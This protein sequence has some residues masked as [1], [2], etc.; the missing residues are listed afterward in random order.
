MGL[1]NTEVWELVHTERRK[2]VEDLASVSGSQ[3]ETP[4]LCPGWSVHDVLAHLVDTANTGRL[5]FVWSMMR[6]RGDFDRANAEG[7]TRYKSDDPGQTVAALRGMLELTKTPP[8]NRATR[9]V[10][11]FVHGEDI[12]RPLR[13]E[14]DYPAEG[15][16]EALTYQLRTAV[17][18]GGGKERAQ[19]LRLIDADGGNS[20]GEGAEVSGSL[21]DLL[22]VISGRPVDQAR[23]TGPGADRL[24][25]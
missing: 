12:R 11:A 8:A 16:V 18:F 1:S 13:I 14:G 4:S 17:S 6:A 9:L 15:I 19:G 23:L 5:A 22:L 25:G 7:V 2:L 24:A 10:E 3:W 20:W 21:I